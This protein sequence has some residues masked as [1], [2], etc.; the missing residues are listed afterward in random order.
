MLV[1]PARAK[2]ETRVVVTD[3]GL[4]WRSRSDESTAL[5]LDDVGGDRD[6]RHPGVH[7]PRTG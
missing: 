7:G 5:S 4:A 2:D 6:R 3:F 1:K